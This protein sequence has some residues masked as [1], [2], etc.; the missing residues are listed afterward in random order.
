MGDLCNNE[1]LLFPLSCIKKKKKK[2]KNMTRE[3]IKIVNLRVK[4][5]NIM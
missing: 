1:L 4:L 5:R 3:K 2:K